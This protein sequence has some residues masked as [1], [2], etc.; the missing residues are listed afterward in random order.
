MT[1]IL[2][3]YTGQYIFEDRLTTAFEQYLAYCAKHRRA[4]MIQSREELNSALQSEEGRGTLPSDV[5]H[6]RDLLAHV[7][8]HAAMHSRGQSFGGLARPFGIARDNGNLIGFVLGDQWYPEEDMASAHNAAQFDLDLPTRLAMQTVAFDERVLVK[9]LDGATRWPE[10]PFIAYMRAFNRMA[11]ER[12]LP[13]IDRDFSE[14][15]GEEWLEECFESGLS[16]EDAIAGLR[17]QGGNEEA[18]REYC[19]FH[20]CTKEQ[21]LAVFSNPNELPFAPQPAKPG[22]KRG[23]TRK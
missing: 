8:L 21:L 9:G 7:M 13:P 14:P 17:A 12:D 1:P 11:V 2:D 10:T 22:T 4:P 15:E 6:P 16:L 5:A 3:D 19:E 23:A 18:L 20:E